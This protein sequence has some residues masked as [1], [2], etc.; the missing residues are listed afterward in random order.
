MK[1]TARNKIIAICAWV[2]L[3]VLYIWTV[4]DTGRAM[5]AQTKD[6]YESYVEYY[7]EEYVGAT[8]AVDAMGNAFLYTEFNDL[9]EEFKTDMLTISIET[10]VYI[11]LTLMCYHVILK[12]NN[13]SGD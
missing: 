1:K 5:G 4:G 9:E 6:A 12:K 13:S 8:G 3:T 7:T 2:V 10:V 11:V